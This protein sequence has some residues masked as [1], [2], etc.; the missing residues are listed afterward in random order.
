MCG[1]L[2]TAFPAVAATIS[3]ADFTLYQQDVIAPNSGVSNPSF[4]GTFIGNMRAAASASGWGSAGD[5]SAP[6][7]FTAVG[8]GPVPMEAMVVSDGT[9]VIGGS[10]LNDFFNSW[11][12]SADVAGTPYANESG[13]RLHA[14]LL[15]VTTDGPIT[16][17]SIRYESHVSLAG[18]G[19]T[20]NTNT[21]TSWDNHRVGV[22]SFGADG[23]LGGGDDVYSTSGAMSAN[24]V[25][26]V[27]Y[28]GVGTAFQASQQLDGS[29]WDA[30]MTSQ[31]KLD[32]YRSQWE[33][34]F[35]QGWERRVDYT[36]NYTKNAVAGS[37]TTAGDTTTV[38][39]EPAAAV[40]A[41]LAG[42]GLLGRRRC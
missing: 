30:A 16:V 34:A 32:S 19:A 13:S 3:N 27:I 23:V 33:A 5:S 14:A 12:G 35:A 24:P 8:A 29:G 17:S 36:I 28:S 37:L 22:A 39:P 25:L 41:V 15:L 10:P 7:S 31:E 11:Y 26:A 20:I 4:A 9:G 21:L 6:G 38:V 1:L 40:L 2:G 42:L 18:G